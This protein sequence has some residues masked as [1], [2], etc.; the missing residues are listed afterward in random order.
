[1]ETIS[2]IWDSLWDLLLIGIG[3][4]LMVMGI[5]V[6][7]KQRR[8]QKIGIKTIAKVIVFSDEK[9]LEEDQA[10]LK[11]PLFIFYD[12]SN[13]QISIKGKSNSICTMY[14]TTPV[15]YNPAKPETEYY[16]PNKDFMVKHLLFFVGLFFLSLG[17]YYL[18]KH[19]MEFNPF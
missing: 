14:E 15:C 19:N 9:S 13:N 7:I 17:I 11:I 16:L 6:F 2:L 3:L 4:S 18:R 8:I 1:M 12:S 5:R 10:P